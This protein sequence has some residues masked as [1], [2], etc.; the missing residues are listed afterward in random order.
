MKPVTLRIKENRS[1]IIFPKGME[2]SI[3]ADGSGRAVPEY[4]QDPASSCCGK[5][6]KC[7]CKNKKKS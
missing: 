3:S 6:V 7:G 5:K 2:I 1:N 4:N